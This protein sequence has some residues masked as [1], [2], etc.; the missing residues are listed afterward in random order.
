MKLRIL[1]SAIIVFSSIS[2]FAQD[3]NGKLTDTV[4]G[5][6]LTVEI[7]EQKERYLSTDIFE[8]G[9]KLSNIGQTPITIY[10]NIGWGWSSSLFL[11]VT[12]HKER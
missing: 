8:I 10:N 9:I 1:L 3:K 11:A 2:V 6:K 7:K 4:N 5:L 12:D